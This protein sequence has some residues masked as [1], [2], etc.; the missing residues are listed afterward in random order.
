MARTVNTG[1]RDFKDIIENNDFYVD[2]TDFIKEWWENRD[3]VT[4]ITRPR[5]FGKTLNMNMLNYFFFKSCRQKRYDITSNRESG[6]GR[7]D[8]ML[9]P[10]ET[11]KDAMIL[12][13]KTCDT[14]NEKNLKDTVKAA[15]QQIIDKKY[16]VS[17]EAKGVDRSKIRIYGFAFSGKEVFID[18]GYMNDYENSHLTAESKFL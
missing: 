13:F 17:F 16:A 8:V 3:T 5:R 11:G 1:A 9:L 15:L 4:L 2:K 12:E 7:Y 18:G 10:L 14:A 6:D